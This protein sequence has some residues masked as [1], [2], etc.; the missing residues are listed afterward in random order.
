MQAES[1]EPIPARMDQ[2]GM[3][4]VDAQAIRQNL[5]ILKKQIHAPMMAVVKNNGYGLGLREYAAL[6]QR[7]GITRFGVKDGE[8]A[9]QLRA[10][11]IQGEI[12]LLAPVLDIPQ[13]VR[14]IRADAVLCVDS[15]VAAQCA[16]RAGYLAAQTPCVQLKVDT[17]L[18]RYGFLPDEAEQ[19]ADAAKLFRLKGVYTHFAEPYSDPRFTRK[20]YQRFL[21]FTASERREDGATALLRDGGRAAVPRYAYGSGAHWLGAAGADAGCRKTGAAQGGEAGGADSGGQRIARRLECGLWQACSAQKAAQGWHL[22]GRGSGGPLYRAKRSGSKPAA[23]S[24]PGPPGAA[25]PP[26][27]MRLYSGKRGSG[28]GHGRHQPRCHRPIGDFLPGRGAGDGRLQS[29]ALP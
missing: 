27:V 11:G 17:G 19:A 4:L 24:G 6:L 2:G 20:Q 16:K 14:L 3:I 10:A 26:K 13:L 15:T 21:A 9:L 8:E 25:W 22:T 7:L 12:F 29:G 5:E 28:R 23:L 18:G 1:R